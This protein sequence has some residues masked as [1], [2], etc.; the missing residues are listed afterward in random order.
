LLGVLA[1][2]LSLPTTQVAVRELG[3]GFATLGRAAG[4][5]A[6]AA[7][8]LILRRARLPARSLLPSLLVVTLGVVLGFPLFTAL[9]LQSTDSAHG[10]VIVGL[11]PA[12]T[13]VLGVLR[14]G[15]RPF[16]AFWAAC[17]AGSAAVTVFAVVRGQ[18]LP[19]AADGLTLLAVVAAAAGY[20]EG[21]RLAPLL[22][23][24]QVICWALLL[25]LPLVLPLLVLDVARSVPTAGAAAWSC[26]AYTAVVSMFLGFFAWYRGLELGGVAKISQVQLAQPLLTVAASVL[27]FGQRLEPAVLVAAAAVLV[28]VAAAQRTRVRP[29]PAVRAVPA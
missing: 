3:P 18:G 14:T 4:A 26:F 20:A 23:A 12:A 11:L 28:C 8:Y 9:A 1:F 5:A 10:A 22:G 6:L 24:D 16:P 17:A 21:A 19:T 29:A 15:E 13:A 2:S 25:G 7:G 27:M